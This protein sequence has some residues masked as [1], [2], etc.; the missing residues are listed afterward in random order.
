M[1]RGPEAPEL[2][3][4]PSADVIS[5]F[6]KLCGGPLSRGCFEYLHSDCDEK[7][8]E[9]SGYRKLRCDNNNCRTRQLDTTRRFGSTEVELTKFRFFND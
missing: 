1:S 9:Y 6:C 4:V 2:F 7:G 5:D 8:L 3:L